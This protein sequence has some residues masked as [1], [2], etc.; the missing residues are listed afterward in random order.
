MRYVRSHE[1][2]RAGVDTWP[3]G[4]ECQCAVRPEGSQHPFPL[5]R[6]ARRT[7]N[8][9][10][11][12]Q[13]ALQGKVHEKA[14]RACGIASRRH[15]AFVGASVFGPGL[16]RFGLLPPL[17]EGE[18]EL[19]RR[20][21][22]VHTEPVSSPRILL[23]PITFAPARFGRWVSC[24]VRDRRPGARP[25]HSSAS[26]S[27]WTARIAILLRSELPKLQ[28]AASG[29]GSDPI[30]PTDPQES[31]ER[32]RTQRE[33]L[34]AVLQKKIRRPMKNFTRRRTP[35]GEVASQGAMLLDK[36]L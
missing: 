32:T 20:C 5:G 3:G 30:A 35:Q 19:A 36:Q 18:H 15:V 26:Q 2:D 11:L 33:T 17:E 14:V 34:K 27:A 25:T 29:A 16:N 4:G 6:A 28:R 12:L 8:G 22:K 24:N 1:T 9:R 7:S 13:R 31:A 21:V 23:Q 10:S